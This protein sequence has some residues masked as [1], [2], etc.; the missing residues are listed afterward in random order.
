MPDL[1]DSAQ[2]L[3][4]AALA[5]ALPSLRPDL[6]RY[7][8]RMTGSVIDGE[9]VLQ[10]VLLSFFRVSPRF[11]YDPSLGRFRGYLKRA[12]LNVIRRRWRRSTPSEPL[13]F[14]IEDDDGV[15]SEAA[16]ERPSARS[17]GP[18][19]AFMPRPPPPAEALTSTG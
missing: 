3:D 16:W 4:G 6:H 14:D 11:E 7:C 17:S 1:P 12:T 15:A 9:D 13:E 18:A 2:N 8:A 19:T 10:E 5:A